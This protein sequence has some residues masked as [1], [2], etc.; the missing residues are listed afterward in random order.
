MLVDEDVALLECAY[1]LFGLLQRFFC[2]CHRSLRYFLFYDK[3]PEQ[4]VKPVTKSF[5]EIDF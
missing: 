4:F 5:F 2:G 3:N 1:E